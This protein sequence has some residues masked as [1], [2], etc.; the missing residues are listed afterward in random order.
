M[1]KTLLVLTFLLTS[2]A[3]FS[4]TTPPPPD[5]THTWIIHG[6]NILLINQSSYSNWS[7][8]G[9]NSVA[10]NILLDYDFNYKKG[11]WNWDNNTTFAYGLSK[12]N[13][14]DWRKNDDRIILNS[15][16]GYQAAQYWLYTFYA[17]FQSQ[18]TNGYSYDDANNRTLI[19]APFAPAYLTFGPGFAYKKSDNFRINLSPLA[20]R[21]TIVQ[22]DSLSSIGAYGVT[23]GKKSLFEFGASLDAY[24]KVNLAKN[25]TLEQILKLYSN[26]ISQPQNVYADYTI[27]LFMNVSKIITVNAGLE[28]ISDP[29]ATTYHSALQERQILGAGVTYKF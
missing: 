18:F 6:Q 26:Y 11:K 14:I 9:A 20:A 4:Q 23:P 25:I 8:G 13:G 5:T 7:A 21:I 28:L 16:L 15:L 2:L 22:N 1:K 29:N 10:V 24:Y 17:N 19:S 12:Q 27:N 3:G